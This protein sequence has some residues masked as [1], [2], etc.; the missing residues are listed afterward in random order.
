MS[1]LGLNESS[2]EEIGEFYPKFNIK[3]V[4][5]HDDRLEVNG[6]LFTTLNE[7]EFAALSSDI[8]LGV[9]ITTGL[10]TPHRG[11]INYFDFQDMSF[12]SDT[13]TVDQFG[14]KI[15]KY[16][17]L[18]VLPFEDLDVTNETFDEQSWTIAS[19]INFGTLELNEALSG[20]RNFISYEQF[21]DGDTAD[22]EVKTRSTPS[23][24]RELF[25]DKQNLV[26]KK[27]RLL[28]LSG[29]PYKTEKINSEDIRNEVGSTID[30]L[31][32]SSLD[33]V[34]NANMVIATIKDAGERTII[35]LQESINSIDNIQC[36]PET[37][38]LLDALEP[39]PQQFNSLLISSG[40]LELK[41][42]KKV[43]VIDLAG[44]NTQDLFV[45]GIETSTR[46]S[47][48][49]SNSNDIGVIKHPANMVRQIGYTAYY[50][51]DE[52]GI[53]EFIGP[54]QVFYGQFAIDYYYL[55]RNHCS[56]F[57]LINTDVL[58]SY[59]GHGVV[60]MFM[61][62]EKVSCVV[63]NSDSA[64]ANYNA[65]CDTFFTY[66]LRGE[67]RFIR[68]TNT[69]GSYTDSSPVYDIGGESYKSEVN[70]INTSIETFPSPDGPPTRWGDRANRLF[71]FKQFESRC[72]SY[73]DYQVVDAD[74]IFARPVDVKIEIT[75]NDQTERMF[76]KLIR[77]AVYSLLSEMQRYAE[78][79][80]AACNLVPPIQNL[81]NEAIVEI[82]R[83]Y[84]VNKLDYPWLK[85]PAMLDMLK[86]LFSKDIDGNVNTFKILEEYQY[87]V[88]EFTR[89]EILSN[90]HS[91]MDIDVEF[92]PITK[93]ALI[94]SVLLSPEYTTLGLINL[95]MSEVENFCNTI[96]SLDEI[97]EMNHSDSTKERQKFVYYLE[98]I[99][100]ALL[101]FD[102]D[103]IEFGTTE[104]DEEEEGDDSPR[105]GF[106]G[107]IPLVDPT[108]EITRT[109]REP[110]SGGG[111]PSASTFGNV[112]LRRER[113]LSEDGIDY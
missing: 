60:K 55:L 32:L 83:F 38:K 8:R 91:S 65:G 6:S 41:K 35:A 13:R 81:S 112:G 4:T 88:P 96:L 7:T 15:Y 86:N 71:D 45:T 46:V 90:I 22:D 11:I 21:I 36:S 79:V 97:L 62:P 26:Y 31:S 100:D 106:G 78:K 58:M 69:V 42:I 93:N 25:V 56:I 76:Y 5:I 54:G 2:I 20:D 59:F 29:K 72:F 12:Y 53:G 103:D 57:R 67:N 49:R 24:M 85:I 99:A 102:S 34:V 1:R 104:D 80:T 50:K 77:P 37:L 113:D 17:K 105:G 14:E 9:Y 51:D 61:R 28:S 52:G 18:V 74:K 63:S 84:D 40:A 10:R 94:L 92:I 64:D 101:A 47:P 111:G 30:A 33:A 27:E 16:E 110:E 98:E 3:L 48:F 107:D 73:F 43:K 82:H 19:F 39:L 70:Q 87:L 66:P 68:A 75:F 44:T 89:A 108:V 95:I 109:D 23:P